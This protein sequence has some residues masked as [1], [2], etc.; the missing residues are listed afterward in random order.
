MEYIYFLFHLFLRLR[1]A[2][3]CRFFL[4]RFRTHVLGF[5]HSLLNRSKSP[6]PSSNAL[7]E[8]ME[9]FISFSPLYDEIRYKLISDYDLLNLATADEAR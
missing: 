3:Y 8:V 7:N 6:T 4:Y 1:T 5:K 9:Q 2:N